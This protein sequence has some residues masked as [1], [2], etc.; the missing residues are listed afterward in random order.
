VDATEWD[1]RY[2][3][4]ELVWGTRPNRWIEQVCS[5]LTPGRA[6]DLACGEGRNAIW[7]ASMGWTATGVDFSAVAL[8][9]AA[10]LAAEA[11]VADRTA[12]QQ[13]DLLTYHPEPAAFDLVVLAYLQLPADARGAVIRSAAKALAVGGTLLVVAHD[14]ANLTDGVGGPQDPAVLYTAADV[15]A[16]LRDRE[17]LTVLRAEA[18]LRPVAE[19]PDGSARSAVDALLLARR[20]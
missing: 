3:G 1:A 5:G 16:D 10:E 6:L 11:G 9:R 8:R 19:G 2:G 4:R 14:S 20:G 7:L 12:W 15:Q 13:G 17:D 18:V